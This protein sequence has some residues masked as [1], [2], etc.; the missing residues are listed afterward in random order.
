[1]K[2]LRPLFG[3]L[4]PVW[5]RPWEIFV[6]RGEGSY[7][8]DTDGNRYLD[9]TSGIGVT[10]TGHCHPRVVGAVR[11]QA[12]R[13]LHA[14]ANLLVHQPMLSLVD[15]LR[16]VVP[17]GLDS[18]FFSNSGAE[19]V[20]ASLKLARHATGRTNVIAFEGSFHGRTVG[21]MSLTSSK[22]VYRSGYQPLMSGVFFAPYGDCFRCPKAE[23]APGRYGKS[24]CCHWPLERLRNLLATRSAPEETAAILVEPILGEGGFVIPEPG[25]L[26]GLREICDE[27]GILLVFDEV[28]TGFGRTGRFFASEHFDVVPDI[29][30]M[31]KGIAS[32]LPL[33]GIA[34]PAELMRC[35]R[36]GAHGG[37]YGGNAI[38]CA[39]ADATVRVLVEDGLVENARRQGAEILRR[40][41]ELQK[42]NPTIGDVRGLGLM[43][44]TE[45]VDPETGRPDREMAAAVQQ[46]AFDR[47][48]LLLTCGSHSH[49]VR[50]LPPLVADEAEVETAVDAFR[51]A[52]A[53]VTVT[54]A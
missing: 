51:E 25:F 15:S 44:A 49:V 6:E 48:V 20:E 2:D 46:G 12:G 14:Q 53:D 8:W 4:A 36:V 41:G 45:F 35:W 18:F 11:E 27:H 1:M 33:S 47:N 52:L 17:D 40:L 26:R 28:Q 13:I 42:V 22:E 9:F 3:N 54:A 31:A 29:L 34:A 7:V 37:T 50:W 38:A 16:K 21:T 19:A 23:A 24:R 5:G 10:S 32:G 39:A 30:V 43:I